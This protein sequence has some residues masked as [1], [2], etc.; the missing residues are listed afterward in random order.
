[1]LS[2]STPD[3]K[4]NVLGTQN[5]ALARPLDIRPNI[6]PIGLKGARC[7]HPSILGASILVPT[8]YVQT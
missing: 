6:E 2:G 5:D 1:M 4:I 3:S 7:A 8:A